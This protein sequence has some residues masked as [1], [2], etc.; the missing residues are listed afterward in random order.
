MVTSII[1]NLRRFQALASLQTFQITK[2]LLSPNFDDQ[3]FSITKST[4]RQNFQGLKSNETQQQVI[5]QATS[6]VCDGFIKNDK[7]YMIQG[8]PGTGIMSSEDI[9]PSAKILFFRVVFCYVR[10]IFQVFNEN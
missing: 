4:I 3:L 2:H 1:S 6:M 10:N 9:S 5:D 7:V 8:P